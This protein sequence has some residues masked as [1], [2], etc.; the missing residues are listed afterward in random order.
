[1]VTINPNYMMKGQEN[2]YYDLDQSIYNKIKTKLNKDYLI[3]IKNIKFKCVLDT[4]TKGTSIYGT[5][6]KYYFQLESD[7]N[8]LD[9]YIRLKKSNV[10]GHTGGKTR[11]NAKASSD[12]NEILSVYYLENVIDTVESIETLAS[13]GGKSQ[14][15]V[16]TGDDKG[17]TFDR[18]RILL[19]EDETA[20]RDILIGQQNAIAIK[21]D[22]NGKKIRT[23]YW[24]PKKKPA[25]VSAK[26]PSDV[27]I[28]FT[29]R[30][31]QGYSNKIAVGADA[32]PK[33]NTNIT[34]FYGK[35]SNSKQLTDIQDMINES[36]NDAVEDVKGETAKTALSSFDISG[37]KFSESSSQKA[38]A[39]LSRAFAV[40]R[41]NFY[42]KDFY[43]LF[44]NNLI[45]KWAKHLEDVDNL[46][47]FLRTIY[48]YTYDDPSSTDTPCPYKLLIGSVNGST[49]KDIGK[50]EKLK[51][52]LHNEDASKITNITNFY[53]GRQQSFDVTF[54]YDPGTNGKYDVEIPVTARTRSPGGWSGKSLYVTSSGVKIKT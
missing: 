6:G 35:L 18:L 32:T 10:K 11:K 48:F 15:G 37:E 42:A 52:L 43:H 51:Q 34:S 45:T 4:D 13:K 47:Y 30:T 22:I 8:L 53:D 39:A 3:D 44:R 29:D 40:D 50:D 24:T 28:E 19:D 21:K 27:I 33:F 25:N 38:F 54:K 9:L 5:S 41:L 16:M 49:I 31:Y 17:V 46:I 12:V 23:L 14:T 2:P 7:G 36:W 26:N 20:E 1:M